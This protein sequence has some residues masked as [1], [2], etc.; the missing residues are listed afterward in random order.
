MSKVRPVAARGCIIAMPP[1]TTAEQLFAKAKA[2]ATQ[3]TLAFTVGL[4]HAAPPVARNSVMQAGLQAV[5]AE[6]PVEQAVAPPAK[7][8]K[9]TAVPRARDL[10]PELLYKIDTDFIEFDQRSG[11]D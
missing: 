9:A 4:A 8:L 1:R 6:A 10:A 7:K 11:I 5:V 3:T 2:D